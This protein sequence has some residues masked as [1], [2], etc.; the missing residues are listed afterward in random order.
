MLRC[1]MP[2]W[3]I[4]LDSYT[5]DMCCYLLIDV[6]SEFSVC[7][8]LVLHSPVIAIALSQP[9]SLDA[10]AETIH[11]PGTAGYPIQ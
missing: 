9:W 11:E 3:S 6:V 7:A 1:I 5:K 4:E 10:K 2:L 8:L